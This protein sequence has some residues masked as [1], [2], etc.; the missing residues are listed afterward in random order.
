MP[1]VAVTDQHNLFAMVKFYKAAL[2]A[3]VKPL[4]GVD[5]LVRETGERAQPSR[6]ALLCQS[7]EG[8]ANVTRL[9]TRAYLEG[10]QRSA[11]MIDRRW[12]TQENLRGLIALSGGMEG[13][14]GRC[15]SNGKESDADQALTRWLE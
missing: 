5:F 3:G 6:I 10:Q 8:Y 11:P 1:A 2:G 15:L 13:D 12:L 4:I 7:S 14:I 9:V